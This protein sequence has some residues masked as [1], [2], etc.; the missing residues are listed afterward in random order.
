[1]PSTTILSLPKMD[2]TINGGW[3]VV[4]NSALN[5]LDDSWTLVTPSSQAFGNISSPGSSLR[6]ARADHKHAFP[7][8]QW[9]DANFL[10]NPS[11]NISDS[12]PGY[13]DLFPGWHGFYPEFPGS[14]TYQY[15]ENAIVDNSS[16]SCKLQVG[17]GT[18]TQFFGQHLVVNVAQLPMYFTIRVKTA[19]AN[20][21]RPFIAYAGTTD[22][23]YH[24]LTF[25][26]GNYHTG[27]N[28]WQTLTVGVSSLQTL[29]DITVGVRV[30]SSNDGLTYIDNA[31]CVVA[32]SSVSYVP[33]SP[34]ADMNIS[35]VFQ[36][37]FPMFVSK[38]GV[39]TGTTYRLNILNVVRYPP[40][41]N[42]TVYGA[43]FRGLN[44]A[45][46]YEDGGIVDRSSFYSISYVFGD[47]VNDSPPLGL[48][49]GN[50]TTM[51]EIAEKAIGGQK[52]RY[53]A[54]PL[55]FSVDKWGG[56]L[57]LWSA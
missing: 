36:N 48:V 46:M 44:A 43:S 35:R 38:L 52:P 24:N 10:I 41:Y 5:L 7:P 34:A 31:M 42:Q 49:Q 33:R 29:G 40:I 54:Y 2:Q 6:V 20:S 21:C 8:L 57:A 9:N 13:L 50:G 55:H 12:V 39:S 3:G 19:L 45:L 30:N 17:A 15:Q 56:P 14:A 28:A 26:Y 22:G 37:Y 32:S 18:V 51:G 47:G 4:H 27:N 53:L 11:F 23:S 16:G 25:V 1:M